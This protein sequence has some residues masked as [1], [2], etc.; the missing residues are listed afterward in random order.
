MPLI[1]VKAFALPELTTKHLTEL[2]FKLILFIQSIT[3]EL[4]VFDFVKTPEIE[5]NFGKG[6]SNPAFMGQMVIDTPV[7]NKQPLSEKLLNGVRVLPNINQFKRCVQTWSKTALK[8][9]SN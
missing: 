3:G 5:E 9:I 2:F 1:P 6:L 4:G 8:G 7:E